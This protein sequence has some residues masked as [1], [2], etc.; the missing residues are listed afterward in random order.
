MARGS[1]SP[2]SITPGRGYGFP[3]LRLAAH[4]NQKLVSDFRK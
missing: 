2:E 1:A 4:E 3:S